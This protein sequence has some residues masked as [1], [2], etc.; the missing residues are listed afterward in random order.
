MR[1]RLAKAYL[2]RY[3]QLSGL[4][5]KDISGWRIPLAAARLTEWVP[6]SEKNVLLAEINKAISIGRN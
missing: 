4:H 6:E 3:L 1:S 2:K 5:K